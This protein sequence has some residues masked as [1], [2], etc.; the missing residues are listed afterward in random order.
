MGKKADRTREKKN[1]RSR[2]CDRSGIAVYI[3]HYGNE[4]KH[5]IHSLTEDYVNKTQIYS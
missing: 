1:K 4:R 3:N 5:D 2:K